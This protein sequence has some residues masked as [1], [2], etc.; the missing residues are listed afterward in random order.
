MPTTVQAGRKLVST[1][2]SKG[3]VT[4]PAEIRR[5]LGLAPHDKIAFVVEADS[6]RIAPTESVIQRTAGIMKNHRSAKTAEQLREAAEEAIAADVIER[7][8]G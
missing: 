8:H 6:V 4:I 3:Q 5:H 7:M 2:T 1:L